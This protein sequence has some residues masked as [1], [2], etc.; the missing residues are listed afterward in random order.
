[1]RKSAWAPGAFDCSSR[2][3]VNSLAMG[4]LNESWAWLGMTGVRAAS[5]T[6]AVRAV[7]VWN[8]RR[9]EVIDLFEGCL[10]SRV[11]ER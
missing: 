11:A 1:V 7:G 8:G 4:S 9:V 10:T 2:R 6:D 3:G 5:T